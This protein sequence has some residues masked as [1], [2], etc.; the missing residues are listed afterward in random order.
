MDFT[1]QNCSTETVA[2]LADGKE[3]T[4]LPKQTMKIKG[5]KVD[6]YLPEHKNKKEVKPGKT[7]DYTISSHFMQLREME[8]SL[9]ELFYPLNPDSRG[10][11]EMCANFRITSVD[12]RMTKVVC[13]TDDGNS[14][15]AR[16][17]K[18]PKPS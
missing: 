9:Y 5:E 7:C 8:Y 6:L 13:W 10:K 15:P 12:G 4:V 17:I 2:A 11:F 1:L 16:W 3:I 18:Y 14:A